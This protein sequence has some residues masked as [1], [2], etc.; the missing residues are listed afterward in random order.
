MANHKI[1]VIPGDGI[2]PEVIR[3]GIKVLRAA[4]DATPGLKLDFADPS[5]PVGNYSRQA[6]AKMDTS[7][8]YGKDFSKRVLANVKS[9]E[10]NTKSVVAKVLLGEADA[11]LVYVTD[12]TPE[13]RRSTSVIAIP[14]NMN[15]IA[16]Y[17]IAVVAR[18]RNRALAQQFVDF[19]LSDQGKDLL[20]KHGFMP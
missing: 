11:G 14:E 9:S 20:R 6:L 1:A 5:V 18:S 8:K 10:P 12:A 19:I 3:E 17:P 16:A 4:A 7:G 2:G 13:V 15:V